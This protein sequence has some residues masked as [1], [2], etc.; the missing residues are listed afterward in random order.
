MPDIF[1]IAALIVVMATVASAV[2][3]LLSGLNKKF[4]LLEKALDNTRKDLIRTET[5]VRDDLLKNRMESN[6]T[7]QLAHQEMLSSL[8]I[9]GDSQSTRISEIAAHQKTQLGVFSSQLDSLTTLTEQKLE[10][11]RD[12]INNR[13]QNLQEDNSRKLEQI[14]HTVDEKLHET[15]EKRLGESFQLVS[16]RLEQVY[17]GLGEMQALA[18]GVGDLKKVLTNVKTRGT[19]GEMS[20]GFI[21][22]ELL[23]PDQFSRNIA[24]KQDSSERVEYAIKLPGQGLQAGQ[25]WLPV[26]AKFPEADYSRLVKAHEE[27]CPETAEEAAKQLE[28]F[29]KLEAKKIRDKYIDPPN[30]TDF[31]IMFLPVESLYAEVLRRPGLC[32]TLQHDFRIVVTGP[33]TFAALLNSLQ[34]GFRTLAIEKRSSEVWTILGTIK[35][36]FCRFGDMLDKTH[37]KL[38]EAGRTIED[39]ARKSRTIERKLRDVQHVPLPDHVT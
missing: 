7:S 37:K 16:E 2:F 5:A 33:T 11:M 4:A 34:M 35:T 12:T 15:L 1:I 23:S 29:I 39:A 30:T 28:K 31:A 17:R 10:Q 18:T 36:E 32:E 22:E 14:R 26:D 9:F 8:K 25:I 38:A 27:A 6:Q 19:W 24:T 20:L 3:F 13:L 21:L